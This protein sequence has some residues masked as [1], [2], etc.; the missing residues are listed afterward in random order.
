MFLIFDTETTGLPKNFNAPVSD[1]DNWPRMVQLAW[2]LHDAEGKLL[3]VA[4]Y[5]VKPDGYTI[6]FNATKVHGLTTEH[7]I[8]HGLPLDEVLQKFQ[9]I[10]KQTTFLVGHNIGFDINIAGAE[11]YRIAQDNP[12]AS[13]LKLDTCTETTASLCQLPGGRGGKFKLPNLSELHETLFQTG[14]DEAHNASADVEATARCFL[15]L[16]RIE[17]FTAKD[18]HTEDSFFE[19]FKKANPEKIGPLGISITSNAIP[20]TLEDAGETEVIAA[21]LSPTEKRQLSGD[22][23]HLRNHTTFSILNSTTNIAALVKAAAD[24]QMPAVGICDTG[25][26]MG[27]FHF[28]SAVNAE[29]ARRK[30]QA[31]ESQIEVSPLKSIL[32]SEIYICNN[33]KDKTV[34]DNG[35][36]TPLFAKNKTGYR[37][38]SMLSSISHTEGFYNVP[39]IDKEALLNY[40]DELIVT[41]GGLSG[42]VPY[43]LLNVGDHQAEEALIWWKTHF[44]DDFYIELNRHG[45]PE[46]DHL[47]EFLLEMA[48]KHDIKYFA[49]NNTYY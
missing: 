28:V 15:E 35:Y 13:F 14:F 47:N 49:S 9:E 10:L 16:I 39:R 3:D 36:L 17:S 2:Q 5:I 31:K 30:K 20:E 12:L 27:A 8:Q 25:N 7:A 41:S 42:E 40:K 6:P 26:L 34:K 32:G 18:L 33:L 22:F 46:E 23:A 29:N 44:G 11:F 21:S 24:M 1:T 38:L 45:I 48:K 4:N 43:L 37:N 19:N